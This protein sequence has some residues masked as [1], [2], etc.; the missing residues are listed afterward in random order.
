M[1]CSL[2]WGIMKNTLLEEHGTFSAA[3]GMVFLKPHTTHFPCIS[4]KRWKFGCDRLVSKGSLLEEQRTVSSV[5]R[6]PMGGG[7]Y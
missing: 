7:F 2:R 5:S 1:E 3:T 4:Y 6:F